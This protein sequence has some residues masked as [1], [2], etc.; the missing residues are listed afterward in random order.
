M[1]KLIVFYTP[2]DTRENAK[3]L[4][5]AL[6]ESR[7]IACANIVA[8]DSVFRWDGVVQD[9]SEFVVI[10]KTTS[11]TAERVRAAINELHPYDVPCILSFA[12]ESNPPFVAW[13][14]G[15]VR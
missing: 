10:A 13:V 8:V 12:A 11:D 1:Q 3:T 4:A 2:I 9:T 7:L 15:E 5:K 6:V 14:S